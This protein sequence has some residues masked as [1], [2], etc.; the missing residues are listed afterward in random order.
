MAGINKQMLEFLFV[1][2]LFSIYKALNQIRRELKDVATQADVDALTAKVG[3]IKDQQ[4]KGIEEVKAE[5]TRVGNAN[6]EVD[7]SALSSKVDELASGT[8][9]LDDIVPDVAPEPTPEPEPEPT[10]EPEP[11]QPTE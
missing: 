5:I 4:A 11:E 10:P 9:Q 3:E 2:P 1:G 6:P 7:L 8:Q